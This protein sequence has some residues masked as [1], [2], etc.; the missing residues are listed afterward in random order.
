MEL[1]A[2]GT[3]GEIKELD[4]VA[5]GEW[6]VFDKELNR[7]ESPA[8]AA[9]IM[10]GVVGILCDVVVDDDAG[11]GSLLDF[12]G[13]GVWHDSPLFDVEYIDDS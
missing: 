13:D 11:L 2:I 8:P 3:D 1:V 5:A 7:L 6:S 12:F 9:V 4:V 10:D